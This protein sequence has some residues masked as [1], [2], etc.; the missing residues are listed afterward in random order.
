MAP[1]KPPHR[2][3]AEKL[4]PQAVFLLYLHT[5]YEV[6]NHKITRVLCRMKPWIQQ[7]YCH[8]GNLI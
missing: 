2:K 7:E 1:L 8:N 3:K 4:L 6:V 5:D